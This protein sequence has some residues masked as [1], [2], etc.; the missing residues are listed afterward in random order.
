MQYGA[1]LLE[2]GK[3]PPY[4]GG[5]STGQAKRRRSAQ[6]STDQFKA[7]QTNVILLADTRGI[8]DSYYHD[9]AQK[10]SLQALKIWPPLPSCQIRLFQSCMAP[11]L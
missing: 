6:D 4:T 8:Q 9:L 11:D 2:T 3:D 10:M 1:A 5:A 7:R